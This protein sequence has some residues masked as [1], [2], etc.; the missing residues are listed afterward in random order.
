MQAFQKILRESS[1]Y[2]AAAEKPLLH[3][4]AELVSARTVNPPGN[5]VEAAEIV[6]RRFEQDGIPYERFEPAPGR[7]SVAGRV[8]SGA[9]RVAIA[10]HLDVVPPGDGWDTDPFQLTV[11][12]GRAYGR[13]VMDNKGP[14]AAMIL[15]GEFLKR[16]EDALRGQLILIAVA[17]E[18]RG[19]TLGLRKL[20]DDGLIEADYAV[21]PDMGHNM[22]RI[23]VGEK[24]A[25]FVEIVSHGKQAHGST[26]HI[27]INAVWNMLSL[28]ERIR[29]LKIPGGP[30]PLFSPPTLNLGSISGGFTPNMVPALCKAQIDIRYLPGATQDEILS[31]VKALMAEVEQEIADAR[32]DL[33]VIMGAPP[34]EVPV[35]SPLVRAVQE[36][37]AEAAGVKAEPT[38]MS[39][40]TVTK[41][42][43]HH[44]IDAVGIG[45]GDF[46]TAH[47]ANE[48]IDIKELL[49]F[50]AALVA[51]SLKLI[52]N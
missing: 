40:T 18:E 45:V 33:N 26:P 12:D 38:G 46:A 11:R 43:V 50:G 44:G 2:F 17:D 29:E 13:G 47:T 36:A 32:F 34:M 7:V 28:L 5:E 21:V 37:I 35:D 19:S 25:L 41:E 52:G 48:S 30:H 42:F 22:K 51:I 4:L 23:D 39:G 24:G 27:G 1:D 3:L 49:R 10:C 9:P 6:M 31:A 14:A 20:L 15:A 16:H 8:G